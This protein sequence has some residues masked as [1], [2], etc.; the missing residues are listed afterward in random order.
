MGATGRLVAFGVGVGDP[1]W[2]IGG[3]G[4]RLG[5]VVV[6]VGV[7]VGVEGG[8]IW[9]GDPTGFHDVD[10]VQLDRPLGCVLQR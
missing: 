5:G 2:D 1:G 9:G 8:I 7:G 10:G 4:V 6:G 3:L